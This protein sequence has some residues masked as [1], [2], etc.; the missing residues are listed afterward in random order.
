MNPAESTDVI[1]L[2]WQPEAADYAE[3]FAARNRQRHVGLFVG[4]M[5]AVG[6]AL[7][8]LAIIARQPGPAAC[9]IAIAVGFPLLTPLMVKRSTNGLWRRSAALRRPVEML[10]D[11]TGVSGNAPVITM[12]PAAMHIDTGGVRH[13]WTDLQKV[14]ETSR[15]LVIQPAGGRNKVFFLLAK[16]GLADPTQEATLRRLLTS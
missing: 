8:V 14:L 5:S 3:A 2:A 12:G 9:G 10:V 6:A 4:V 15:V 1:R 7:A 13:R 16:R 11:A